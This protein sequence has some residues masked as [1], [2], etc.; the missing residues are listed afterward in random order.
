MEEM[1]AST[2]GIGS[3][4]EICKLKIMMGVLKFIV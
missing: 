1:G 3:D 4:A 2:D